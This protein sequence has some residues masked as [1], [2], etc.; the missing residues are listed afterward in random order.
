MQEGLLAVSEQA[1]LLRKSLAW[2]QFAASDSGLL[3]LKEPQLRA[4]KPLV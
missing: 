1:A 3:F 2:H 4:H